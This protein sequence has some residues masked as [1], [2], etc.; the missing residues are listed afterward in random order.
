M[1]ISISDLVI[2]INLI[3]ENEFKTL[4]DYKTDKII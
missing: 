3:F 2:E 1:V 4:G